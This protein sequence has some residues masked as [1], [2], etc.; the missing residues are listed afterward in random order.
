MQVA[1]IH[2]K[3]YN[4]D[5]ASF[6]AI[7]V[8]EWL[9]VLQTL[10]ACILKLFYYQMCVCVCVCVLL[11]IRNGIEVLLNLKILFSG[12]YQNIVN[13]KHQ[14]HIYIWVNQIECLLYYYFYLIHIFTLFLEFISS[15][16]SSYTFEYISF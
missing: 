12:F 13:S 10:D 6:I 1:Q 5:V 9:C 4:I 3:R 2:H 16:N 7:R 15:L 11:G 8:T 14:I